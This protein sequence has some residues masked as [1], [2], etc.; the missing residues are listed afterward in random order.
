MRW[1]LSL[2][3]PAVGAILL[4]GCA[5]PYG[6]ARTAQGQ[7]RYDEAATHFEEVLAKT[8]DRLKAL[9][10]L[11]V[12]RY[13]LGAY[14]E[15]VRILS[16]AVMQAPTSRTAELYLG[17]GHLQKGEDALA[18]AHLRRFIKLKPD[19]RL[20][21][22]VERVLTLIRMTPLSSELRAFV[23]ESLDNSAEWARKVS[24]DRP[25]PTIATTW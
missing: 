23:A 17:L 6:K 20:Q 15:A 3:S 10:G 8:P 9:V 14:D 21:Q 22:E 18:E 5:T 25:L 24:G 4:V 16:R 7:G 11:G 1:G 12:S 2:L 19:M 13:K